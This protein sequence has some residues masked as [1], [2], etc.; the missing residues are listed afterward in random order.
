MPRAWIS[1]NTLKHAKA[2]RIRVATAVQAGRVA[3]DMSDDGDGFDTRGARGGHGLANMRRRAAAI[4]AELM[5]RSSHEGTT[6]SLLLP[7]GP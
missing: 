4:G 1:I 7:A 2:T 6:L 5:L 3:I